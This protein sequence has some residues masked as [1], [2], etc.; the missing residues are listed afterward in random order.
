MGSADV[1][2]QAAP[3]SWPQNP[4]RSSYSAFWRR[5]APFVALC[6]LVLVAYNRRSLLRHAQDAFAAV[7]YKSDPA[8]MG[9][10]HAAFPSP[11]CCTG[12]SC[13]PKGGG[14]V[15]VLSTLSS[16]AYLPL[17][18][19]L[20]CTLRMSNPG[21]ELAV[22]LEPGL[23]PKSSER[24]LRKLGVT[25]VQTYP[26]EYPNTYE[27]RYG[28]N[29]VKLKAFNLTQYD[30][31]LMVDADT[32]I[33]GDVAPLW[34]L[35]TPFAAVWDQYRWLGR[36][37][38]GLRGLNGG[39]LLL[40]PCPAVAA[41]MAGI[42]ESH[43][44]LRFTHRAAEQ[45]FLDWYFRYTGTVLPL[46]Y[47]VQTAQSLVGNLTVGGV[48]PVVLHFTNQKPWHGREAGRLGHQFLCS[49]AD[50]R[51]RSVAAGMT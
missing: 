14:R 3:F 25:L 39:V 33:V 42:L 36:H 30:A 10:S 21:L 23:L 22:L 9:R 20:E 28:K 37:R 12:Q 48:A 38:T 31:V 4:R 15:V 17:F 40:R 43:P 47:N 1:E 27:P 51:R 2:L 5:A 41:H 11:V 44:K 26:L 19:Q 6:L 29:F 35:P 34:S 32:V 18:L 49:A 45:D 50:L 16:P 46:E 7:Y 13:V 8:M 24:L